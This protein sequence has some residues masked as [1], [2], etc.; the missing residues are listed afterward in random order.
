MGVGMN[1]LGTP[2]QDAVFWMA[3]GSGLSVI[4]TG[5]WMLIGQLIGQNTAKHRDPGGD[6]DQWLKTHEYVVQW[7]PVH[8]VFH[9]FPWG[10]AHV[11]IE[12]RQ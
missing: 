9:R 8:T 11:T 2:I 7:S 6:I 4:V 10:M 5:I 12:P 1:I 3:V